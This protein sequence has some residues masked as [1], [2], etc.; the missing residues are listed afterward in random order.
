[1]AGDLTRSSAA[2]PQTAANR[3]ISSPNV[4]KPR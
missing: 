2:D 1:M 3:I 4:S